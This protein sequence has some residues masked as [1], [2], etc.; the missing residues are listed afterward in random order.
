[1]AFTIEKTTVTA[2]TRALKAEY[3][4]ELA[5]DLKAI[6]GLDAET[7]LS[8]ILST[9]ILVEINREVVRS[10]YVTPLL[11]LRLTQRQLVLLTLTQTPTDVGRLR[12]SKV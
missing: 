1:M 6:H 12:S 11:V 10:L 7:E 8:N 9:E 2:V 3:T 4:M 5:Q